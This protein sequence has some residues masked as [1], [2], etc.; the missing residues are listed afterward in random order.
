MNNVKKEDYAEKKPETRLDALEEEIKSISKSVNLI[1]NKMSAED[2]EKKP[3]FDEAEKKKEIGTKPVNPSPEGGDVK[4]P[5]APAG[6][7]DE[8]AGPEGD[9]GDSVVEKADL[10]KMINEAAENKVNEILKGLGIVKS[11]TPRSNHEQNIVKANSEKKTEYALDLLKRA[12][13]GKLSPA[14]MNRETKSF[15]K[16][17]YEENL[18]RVLNIGEN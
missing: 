18:K 9:K 17:N 15:V 12:K 3:I 16:K 14:D 7:T 4:L 5:K 10:K 1:L 13:E 8:E 11:T 6:E 2:E